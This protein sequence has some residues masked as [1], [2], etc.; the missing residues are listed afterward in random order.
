MEYKSIYAHFLEIGQELG[1]LFR[2][3]KTGRRHV[4]EFMDANDWFGM[5]HKIIARTPHMSVHDLQAIQESITLWL[6]AYKQP[7]RKKITLML[8]HF[9]DRC[10]ETCRLYEQ[11]ISNNQMADKPSGWMLLDYILSEI[12]REI[13]D[14]D[15]SGLQ[16]L[17]ALLDDGATRKAAQLFADFLGT[18]NQVGESISPWKYTFNI[19]DNPNLVIEAYPAADFSVMAYCVFNEDMWA[20]QNLIE[21]AINSENFANLWLFAALHFI[22]ALRAQDM[23]RLPAPVL[24]REGKTIHKEIADKVFT[25]HDATALV[26][27]LL[28]RL[29]LKPIFPAKTAGKDS[30]PD[31]KL[32]VPK[33]LKTPFGII[34]AIALAHRNKMCMG[35]LVSVT[36]FC[37]SNI[38][39]FFGEDFIK[40][41]GGNGFSTRRCNKSYLQGIEAIGGDEHG[42]P[43]GYMLAALARSHKGGISKLAEMTDIYLKDAQF[44]GYSPEFIIRQMFERGIFSFIPAVLL[45]LYAGDGY[46]KLPITKQTRL[47]GEI[48]LTAYQIENMAQAM[49][50]AIAKSRSAVR[51]IIHNPS[52]MKENVGRVLQN[53]ASGSA[54]GKQQDYFCLMIAARLSCPFAE[55]AGCFGCGYE[56]YTKAAMYTLMR[57]HKR[58]MTAKKNAKSEEAQRYELIM[59][60]AILPAAKE[61][62]VSAELLYPDADIDGLLDIMEVELN[63]EDCISG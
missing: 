24:P 23:V 58:L 17:I 7:S 2:S 12:D 57:E 3:S 44:R 22:C 41:L 6:S 48:G 11:F 45:E 47:I 4:L 35:G 32:I 29:K 28:F 38:R 49:E 36:K 9:K 51:E 34:M 39:K 16:R 8:G 59:G 62:I 25:E 63:G 19:R 26:E 14:Y 10:P 42:K 21:K 5:E 27:E 1:S 20:Q 33:S 53:I 50:H 56:I 52:S 40:A 15:E 55:R 54:L 61:M 31:I 30:I 18:E 13:T 37:L 46:T 60:Q 43:K